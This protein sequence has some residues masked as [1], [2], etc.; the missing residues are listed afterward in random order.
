MAN[1]KKHEAIRVPQ[2]WKDQDRALVIQIE[3]ILDD[4]YKRFGR[5]SWEDLGEK[6]Q[7]KITGIIEGAVTAVTWD[8]TNK[9]LTVTINDTVSDV[10]TSV[11]LKSAMD[12]SN[13][14]NKSSAT[15]RSELTSQ[16][17][18]DA[19]GYTPPKVDTK[20]TT[21]TMNKV[22][23]KLYIVGA[24]TQATNPTTNTNVNVYI[25]ADNCLYSNGSKVVTDLTG[26]HPTS[27][28]TSVSAL[29]TAI[30]KAGVGLHVNCNVDAAV[31]NAVAGVSKAGNITAWKT[32]AVINYF[33]YIA[34]D[35]DGA[36]YS[37]SYNA[38]DGTHDSAYD[39]STLGDFFGKSV[40]DSTSAAAM[41]NNANIPTNRTVRNAIYN[42]LD[43][44]SGAGYALDARQ[45]YALNQ[46]KQNTL[47][48]EAVK[49]G[50]SGSVSAGGKGHITKDV[51][52]S[53]YTPIGVVGWTGSGTSNFAIS[54]CYVSGTT[55][56][57]YYWNLSS[58]SQTLS[59]INAYILYQK[60]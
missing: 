39:Y 29:V 45:G 47:L 17:V 9:K 60:N 30:E 55:F 15:I 38:S 23:D 13:V 5:L 19:L 7:E 57:I 51:S 37:G 36:M 35:Y 41:G 4:I 11:T 48:V 44:S 54:E 20:N 21:G 32:S 49:T 27:Q 3:R 24:E 31:M 14:E 43:K 16:N 59:Y 28:I 10:V 2:G 56:Y 22:N 18:T 33:E 25:G 52:K 53:G 26:I 46:N 42:G 6:L 8:N 1:I 34:V 12:L 58:A 40:T 50:S